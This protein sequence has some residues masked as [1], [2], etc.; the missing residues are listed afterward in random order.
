MATARTWAKIRPEKPAERPP[1]PRYY[2]HWGSH[3]RG[4]PAVGMGNFELWRGRFLEGPPRT[5]TGP[6][7]RRPVDPPTPDPVA[8]DWDDLSA[9]HAMSAMPKEAAQSSRCPE[10][11][12]ARPR[13]GERKER[14]IAVQ[15]LGILPLPK[16]QP[17]S[18]GYGVPAVL[19]PL[20][21]CAAAAGEEAVDIPPEERFRTTYKDKFQAAPASTTHTPEYFPV[22]FVPAGNRHVKEMA[23]NMLGAHVARAG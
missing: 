12:L 18:F 2:R 10:S 8:E 23:L 9:M 11:V 6:W 7:P 22:R 14:N 21:P 15:E 5:V 1:G 4:K 16:S 19:K 13:P 20:P 17:P 3:Y